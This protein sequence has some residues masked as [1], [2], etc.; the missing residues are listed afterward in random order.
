MCMCVWQPYKLWASFCCL[1]EGRKKWLGGRGEEDVW[2]STYSPILDNEQENI[3]IRHFLVS[4]SQGLAVHYTSKSEIEQKQDPTMKN[5]FY[6][7][8]FCVCVCVCVGGGG[9]G[10]LQLRYNLVLS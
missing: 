9:G 1:R 7:I 8:S 6:F 5:D 3:A 4:I 10:G 2:I